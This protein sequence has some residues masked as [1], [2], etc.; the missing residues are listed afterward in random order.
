VSDEQRTDDDERLAGAIRERLEMLVPTLVELSKA[1]RKK[2]V[3][4]R[5]ASA[6][7]ATSR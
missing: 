1:V 3:S 4:T 5:Q 2:G 6:A 7:T